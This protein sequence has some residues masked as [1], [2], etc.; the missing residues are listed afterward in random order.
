MLKGLAP[1]AHLA[2]FLGAGMKTVRTCTALLRPNPWR[3]KLISRTMIAVAVVVTVVAAIII[4]V[5]VVAV[6]AAVGAT[7]IIVVF[8]VAVVIMLKTP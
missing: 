1:G 3:V 6:V 5:F 7:I 4:F 8:V 2:R